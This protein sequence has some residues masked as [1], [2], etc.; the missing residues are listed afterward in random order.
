MNESENL[1]S[2]ISRRKLLKG[3]ASAILVLAIGAATLMPSAAR[4]A[5]QRRP[6]IILMF[7]D[8][9]ARESMG[10]T[11]NTVIP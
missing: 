11:G 9:Q 1:N 10:Y 6:N 8:D 5:K 7:A 2:G 4:A 3:M